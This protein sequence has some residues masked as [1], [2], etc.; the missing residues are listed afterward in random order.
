MNSMVPSRTRIEFF[1]LNGRD[2]WKPKI[3]TLEGIWR[4]IKTEKEYRAYLRN[5]SFFKSNIKT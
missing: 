5:M 4:Q 3:L 1:F 2:K